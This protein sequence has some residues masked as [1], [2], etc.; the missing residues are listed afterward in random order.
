M[1]GLTKKDFTLFMVVLAM[2]ALAPFIL[3]PFPQGSSLAQMFNAGYPDLMQRFVIFGILVIGFNILFGL[4][5]Y[6]SFGHAAFLGVGSYSAVWMFKLLGMNVIPGILLSM[7]VAGIFALAWGFL[8]LGLFMQAFRDLGLVEHTLFNYYWP[9]VASFSEML[10]IMFAM[11]FQ[12]RRVYQGK[13]HAERQYREHLELSKSRLEEEVRLRT[14]ELEQAKRAAEL[15]ARTDALTGILNRRSFLH[16][17]S[18]RLKL[19]QR[20]RKSCCLLMFDL[21]H[22][23]RIND[24][25]G[26]SMGDTVLC[27]F[28]E[29]VSRAVRET[30]VFGRL[31]GEEFAL[32]VEE[33]CDAAY[34]LAERLRADI[35]RIRLPMDGE[36]M[37]L[38]A[39]IGLASTGGGDAIE[40][41]LHQ[42][43]EAMYQAKMDGRNR[44]ATAQDSK[45][46]DGADS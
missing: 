16:D 29:T 22:F 3:N 9:P 37:M 20:Q 23:K 10:T 4:T 2:V 24:T 8:V 45:D 18:L 36:A 34:A 13:K 35:G 38:T 11:G 46:L 30:D 14:R 42:A 32:L 6:L 17:A 39:S 15:E 43:D 31:G 12:M 21:D 5:G 7:V 44:V 1:L 33:P 27:Q 19:A 40:E 26:H 41:L 25:W 28:T